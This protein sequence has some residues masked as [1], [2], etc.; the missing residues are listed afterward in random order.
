MPVNNLLVLPSMQQVGHQTTVQILQG[1]QDII[2]TTS[3]FSHLVNA[4]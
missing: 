2:F 3:I 4:L 1:L